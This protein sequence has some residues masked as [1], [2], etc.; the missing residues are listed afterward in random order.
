M[1]DIMTFAYNPN[2][3][4]K[5]QIY[6]NPY[7]KADIKGGKEYPTLSGEVLFYRLQNCVLVV[8]SIENLPQTKSGFFA[9]HLHEGKSCSGNE[10]DEFADA[11]AHFNPTQT[12]HPEHAGDFPPLLSNAGSAYL[13]F[14]TDRFKIRDIIGKTIVIH[15]N[16]DDFKTQ[17]SGNAGEKIACGV[18]NL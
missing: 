4:S 13:A 6:Y 16:P 8:A 14:V 5:K 3:L 17:P 2:E 11:G 9:F 18:I 7:A 12:Q 1:G 10:T 15:M